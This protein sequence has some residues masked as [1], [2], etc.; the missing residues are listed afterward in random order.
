MTTAYGPTV[1]RRKL[2][3][4]IRRAREAAGFTQEQVAVAMDWSLSKLIRIEAGYVSISTN[5]VKALLDHYQV[6]DPD[7]VA[8][9]VQLAR[10]SRQRTWWSQY[11]DAV[12]PAYY[13]YIGLEAESSELYFYQSV[14]M[15][16]L[17]QTAAY[18]QAVLRTTIPKLDDPDE[19]RASVTLRLRRQQELLGRADP[20]K[21]VVV[22]DEAALHRQTGGPAVILEQLRHLVE[23]AESGR[24][25]VQVLPFISTIY[26]PLGQ[27]VI[28]RFAAE[29]DADVVYLESTGLEDVID[30]ADAVTAHLRTFTGLR[31]A[32]LT[33]ADSLRRIAEIAAALAG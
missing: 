32:A 24:I 8:E 20:P 19:A 1:G 25:T 9:L 6:R 18:A 3:S 21:I 4:A 10:V 16:G 11:R 31:E 27:F 17:L 23:L 26:T 30:D 28:V 5:D 12:R 2:R 29:E 33:P 13:S 15:P 22:F 14:G 7:Q